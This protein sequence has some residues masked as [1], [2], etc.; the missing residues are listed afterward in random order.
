MTTGKPIVGYVRKSPRAKQKN[1]GSGLGKAAQEKAI[2]DLAATMASRVLA[3]YTEAESG[4]RND[5]PELQRAIAHAKRSG[6]T[7]VIAKMDRL[8]RNAAFLLALQDSGLDF[9]ACDNPTANKLTVGI[10]AVIAQDERERIS[11]RTKEALAMYKAA[12]GRLGASLPQ[13][14]NLTQEARV[15]G[16]QAAGEA[17]RALADAA[18]ADLVKDMRTWRDEGQTLAQIASLLNEAGHTTRRGKAWNPVQVMR[19]L[20]RS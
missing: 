3:I 11:T 14:R 1:F 15:K 17:V 18:Y 7:L 8:S 16:A 2:A 4:K 5:R 20:E 19:V 10:M 12:G 6:A 9:V 13:C